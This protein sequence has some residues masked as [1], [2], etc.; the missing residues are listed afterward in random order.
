MQRN[1]GTTIEKRYTMASRNEIAQAMHHPR[2]WPIRLWGGL[3][4]AVSVWYVSWL[5]TAIDFRVA[6]LSVPFV[7]ANFL[8]V[9]SAILSLVNNWQR[10]APAT[11][12]IALEDAPEVAVIVPTCGESVEMVACTVRSILAQDWPHAKLLIMVSDDAHNPAMAQMVKTLADS[13]P[14]TQIVYYEPPKRGDSARRGDAKAGNLNG[15]LEHIAANYPDIAYIETRDADDEVGDPLFLRQCMGQLVGNARV[16]FVQ[17]IKEV[18]VSAGDPFN[19][20]DRMF[21]R[22]TMLARNAANAVLPCGSGVV[23]RRAA[24]DDMGGFP[25]WN[26]VEDLTSGVEALRRGWR[27]LYLP[28]VGVVSQVAPEDIPNV[29]KQRGTWAVDTMR[30][31]FWGNK[32]GLSLRQHLHFAEVGLFYVLGF[33]NL[34]FILV[35][36]FSLIFGIHPLY[37]SHI[38]YVLHFWPFAVI[39]EAFLAMLN[40]PYSYEDLWRARQMWLGLAPVYAKACLIALI[41]GPNRKPVYK[42]TRKNHVFQWYWRETLLHIILF[43]LLGLS[44]VYGLVTTS[45]LTTLDLGSALWAAFNIV[46]LGGFIQKGWF[47]TQWSTRLLARF[48]PIRARAIPQLE[49]VGADAKLLSGVEMGPD[50]VFSDNTEAADG[51]MLM[52]MPVLTTHSAS[53]T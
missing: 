53:L 9:A 7:L 48:R 13:Y 52:P 4:A 47:G 24:L 18:R 23:W 8:V 31:T 28:I 29:F 21:Y 44:L 20:Q 32:R 46:L 51:G 25:T 30:M 16:A 49:V 37:A 27:G 17:T 38:E 36:V 45:I 3:L 1:G 26:L 34:T 12:L 19:N 35:P 22:S 40:A 39:L 6:W 33:A 15:A 11:R 10:T 2:Q 5:V 43:G 14:A 41:A 50:L 42:V